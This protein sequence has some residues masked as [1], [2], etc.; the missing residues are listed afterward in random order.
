[1]PPVRFTAPTPVVAIP[2]RNEAERI[3]A[4]LH[5]LAG[6]QGARLA[7]AVLLLNNCTDATRDM[8]PALAPHLPFVV[9]G[10]ERTYPAPLAHAGTARCEAMEIAA[11]LAGPDGVILTTDADGT[12]APD[13]LANT[14]AA[15]EEGAD[16]VCGRALINPADAALIPMHLHEDDRME[17]GYGMLL[18]R[19]H[20][21]VDPDPH[22]PWPRHA[23]HSG[24]SI[25]VSVVM[26]RR[27]GGLPP[28]PLGEDRAFLKAVRRV[29]GVIRHAPDV[30]VTVSGRTLGRA[31]GGMAD[32]MARRLLRQDDLLD[33]SLEPALT[34]L[35]RAR[36][37]AALRRLRA[38]PR[39]SGQ[40]GVEMCGLAYQLDLPPAEVERMAR[41]H[42]LGVAWD[43]LEQASPALVRVPVR[44]AELATHHRQARRVV[45]QL[46]ARRSATRTAHRHRQPVN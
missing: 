11:S 7:H 10:V 41:A 4:C 24:A 20:D 5:A 21:L 36:A 29:D 2:V 39:M 8:L 13:W 14:L 19:I 18:D 15:F 42:F 26:W 35:R 27:A 40:W 1:M 31:R 32:T 25:A 38:L 33:E 9:H 22:D 3:A 45:R 43:S 34:C 30:L 6:Q 44:R 12:V 23:E 17:T 28:L 16:A 37:R 46:L